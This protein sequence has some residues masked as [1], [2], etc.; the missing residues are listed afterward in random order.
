MDEK[1]VILLNGEKNI[2][3]VNVDVPTKIELI[4]QSTQINEYNIRNVLSVTELFNLER[5][6]TEIYRIYGRIEYLS[7]LNGLDVNYSNIIDFFRPNHSSSNNRTIFN[8]FDFYLVRPAESGYIQNINNGS[9]YNRF[10]RVVATPDH[11]DL[12]KAGFAKNV[13]NEQTYAFNFTV[14]VDISE[15]R[16]D[17]GMPIT[18]LYLYVQYKP[19]RLESMSYTSWSNNGIISNITFNPR[20]FF[21]RGDYVRTHN[22][23]LMGDYV[24][25]SKERFWQSQIE[26]QTFRITS[27]FITATINNT[28]TPR[29]IVFKYNPF[30]PIKL[31]YFEG[32]ISRAN[33][34]ST[35]Y[36]VVTNIPNYATNLGDGN[37]VWR[38]IMP[39]GYVDPIIGVGTNHPFVNKRR[40][41]FTSIVLDVVPDFSDNI[42]SQV[43]NNLRFGDSNSVSIKPINNINQINRPCQ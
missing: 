21:V 39:E 22:D 35:S 33:S 5:Q 28:D 2:E 9:Q 1:L 12:F 7:F 40:Y 43:F 18:E 3:S 24:E 13:Y 38:E 6:E 42:T 32:Q 10:F 16:D 15:L 36:D 29:R 14:D 30:V 4:S 20:S 26:E 23:Q 31:R 17:F 41:V 8:S 19:I 25:Y 34:G 27:D 37:F 11:F